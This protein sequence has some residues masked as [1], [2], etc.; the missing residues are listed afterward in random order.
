MWFLQSIVGYLSLNRFVIRVYYNNNGA[1]L[2]SRSDTA[3]W[4]MTICYLIRTR[5]CNPYLW[6]WES[7]IAAAVWVMITVTISFVLAA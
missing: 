4:V 2:R 7:S 1:A 6:I 5:P 3:I